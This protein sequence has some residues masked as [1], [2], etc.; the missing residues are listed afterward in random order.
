MRDRRVARIF[1]RIGKQIPGNLSQQD[2]I[3]AHY[4]KVP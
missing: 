3:A 1:D 4:W 2:E